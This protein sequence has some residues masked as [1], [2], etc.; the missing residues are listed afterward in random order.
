VSVAESERFDA[1]TDETL[2]AGVRLLGG[3]PR[4]RHVYAE[5]GA[6]AD[7]LA[8]WTERLGEHAWVV[9]RERAVA[10]G[11]FGPV[12]SLEVRDRVGD[13]VVAL[14]GT[15]AVV[16]SR[17]E[18]FLARLPGQHGSLTAAEQHIPL[19]LHRG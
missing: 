16:R 10:E 19:V 3:D 14:R 11:W 2:R 12:T 6:A 8:A 1:D 17:A 15:A 4:S 5:P 7:V 13:V 9:P 18:K